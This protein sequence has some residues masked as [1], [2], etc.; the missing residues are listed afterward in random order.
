MLA[1][2]RTCSSNL[3]T[4]ESSGVSLKPPLRALVK[5]VRVARV[6][7]T[8]SGFFCKLHRLISRGGYGEM[9]RHGGCDEHLVQRLL[10]GCEVG[11]HGGETLSGHVGE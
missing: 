7:T 10:S 2:F 6:M 1:F 4:M 9:G 8:S 3:K 5:G 11:E